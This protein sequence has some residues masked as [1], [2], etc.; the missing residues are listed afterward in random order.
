MGDHGDVVEWLELVCMCANVL[1]WLS[2]QSAA[3]PIKGTPQVVQ[4]GPLKPTTPL[5]QLA[6][7]RARPH[8]K[9]K[10]SPHQ[11]HQG[12]KQ[13]ARK[14]KHQKRKNR[15]YE[16]A[17]VLLKI[18][19]VQMSNAPAVTKPR[20]SRMGRLV[21][22]RAPILIRRDLWVASGSRGFD[23]CQYLVS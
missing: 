4:V 5:K 13:S 21:G 10:R 7:A 15:K 18:A 17:K 20:G 9:S 3:L 11:K 12:S 2:L 16:I 23:S 6:R 14:S 1:C 19:R 8:S 22:S